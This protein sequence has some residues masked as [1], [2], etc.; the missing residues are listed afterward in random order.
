MSLTSLHVKII[1]KSL[2][3]F[4]LHIGFNHLIFLLYFLKAYHSFIFSNLYVYLL[5]AS[6]QL[7]LQLKR[8]KI[9]QQILDLGV[10]G[11][12]FVKY[13]DK[14]LAQQLFHYLWSGEARQSIKRINIFVS[15]S[16]VHLSSINIIF[17]KLNV[18]L[19]IKIQ[20]YYP[21]F[22]NSERLFLKLYFI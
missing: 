4:W 20:M 13:W 18:Q 14:Y 9:T 5:G 8:K 21:N 17:Y 15:K 2:S 11:I 3:M 10:K 19:I 1:K 6:W 7:N 22:V 16:T 12:V